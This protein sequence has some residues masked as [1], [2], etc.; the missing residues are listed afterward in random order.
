METGFKQIALLILFTF[1][2][3]A[4][5]M[6]EFRGFFL[7]YESVNQ[8]FSQSIEWNEDHPYKEITVTDDNYTF[9]VMS[10]SHVGGTKNTDIFFN[11]AIDYNADGVIMV[12]DL[13][14][15]HAEDYD[16]FKQH[17][18]NRDSMVSFPIV[19][20]HDLYFDGWKQF[21][22]IFGSSTYLFT[23]KTPQ[24]TDLFICLDTGGGTLGSDQF[25]WFKTILETERTKYR[26]CIVFTHNNLFRIRHTTS[27]N[28]LVEE[29]HSL[30][31]LCVKHKIDMV[32]AGHD[33]K[34]NSAI[35]GNTTHITLDALLDN[36]SN[37]GY[38]KLFNKQGE[39]EYEFI[40]LNK[41]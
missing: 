6:F 7:S 11:E 23:V 12:G 2:F 39:I 16:I 38:L 17:L 29:L 35:L 41:P 9:Y 28:P 18:P 36:Y 10:D 37:A 15:G 8:R 40:N 5:E 19:G 22:S 26:H 33:H 13:T 14:T 1:L 4:C 25:N 30:M 24:S 21:Y 27:T 20:N 3:A 32:I 34:K 31:E